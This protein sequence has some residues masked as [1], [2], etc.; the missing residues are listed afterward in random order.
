[1]RIH[2][3]ANHQGYEA[4]ST[5]RS[6]LTSHGH[7]VVWHAAPVLDDNDDYHSIAIR[8]VKGVVADE[9]TG[10]DSRAIIVGGTGAGEVVAANKVHGARVVSATDERYVADARR[11]ADING[12]VIPISHISPDAVTGLVAALLDTPFSNDLDDARR[13][14]NV[15][16]FETNGT[17]E[18]WLIEPAGPAGS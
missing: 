13:I 14:V 1:M 15:A 9:D 6:H 17:I 8:A 7:D 11:H 2:L 12:L 4:A 5:L 16:E 3:S 18:G 10:V